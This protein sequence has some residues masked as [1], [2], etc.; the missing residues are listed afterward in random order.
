[1]VSYH[2]TCLRSISGDTVSSYMAWGVVGV[3][4]PGRVRTVVGGRLS[5]S[6]AYTCAVA[7]QVRV[8]PALSSERDKICT[9]PCV[10]ERGGAVGL[11]TTAVAH[12]LCVRGVQCT[13]W[14][15]EKGTPAFGVGECPSVCWAVGMCA[16]V[17]SAVAAAAGA[18]PGRPV[19]PPVCGLV[20][21]CDPLQQG[22][23]STNLAKV[24][25]EGGLARNAPPS[26]P[27]K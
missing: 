7:Q 4:G 23:H 27:P 8:P 1:M 19:Q 21:G 16:W 3:V 9:S 6:L 5:A 15:C 20:V 10:L 18:I 12:P 25:G 17:G 2:R 14:R 24:A 11:G 26:L 13:F 22:Q